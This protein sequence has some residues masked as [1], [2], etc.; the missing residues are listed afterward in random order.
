M[1]HQ[2][3]P[4]SQTEALVNVSQYWEHQ[5]KRKGAATLRSQAITIALSRQSGVLGTSTAREVGARLGWRVYD[6][7][8]LE[9][10]A[11][12]M[13]L[14]T[15]LLESVDE[16]SRSWL[17]ECM[18]AFAAVPSVT[19]AA[20]V[21][22]LVQT[23]FSLAS[24]GECVIVGRGAAQ[25]LPAESTMRVRLV[26]P[27]EWRIAAL[28]RRLDIS[29]KSAAR[30]VERIDRER[31]SFIKNHFNKD[32]TEPGQYDLILNVSRFSVEACAELI[33]QALHSLKSGAPTA[34]SGS[35]AAAH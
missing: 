12:E 11:G 15:S 23:V 1:D 3:R 28:G 34:G 27:L 18:E 21:H 9:R 31:L 6:H 16:K 35:L 14:R 26:A 22:H 8:L 19:E 30:Q 2:I 29:R 24:H 7:E 17:Q 4:G 25:I 20:Y 13:K 32:A 5:R 33:V 10:I